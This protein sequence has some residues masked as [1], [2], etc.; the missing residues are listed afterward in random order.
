MSGRNHCPYE[1]ISNKPF[2]NSLVITIC[3]T[4]MIGK[5]T[6]LA[7]QGPGL[8]GWSSTN[9]ASEGSSHMLLYD[10]SEHDPGLQC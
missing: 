4:I 9:L 1:T 3:C 5:L 2:A 7:G 6:S 8:D 10:C